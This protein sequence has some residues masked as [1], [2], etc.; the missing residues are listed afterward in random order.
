MPISRLKRVLIRTVWKNEEKDFTPWLQENLD[1]LGE[2]MNM[3]LSPLEREAPVGKAFEADLL[4][5]GPGGDLVVI[6]NQF[7]K[8]D[9]DHLG[10][11]LTYLVNLNAKTA[12]WICENPQPEH[13]EA[14][15]WLNKS[16]ASDIAFYLVRLEAFQMGDSPDCAPHFSIVAEPSS[17]MKEAGEAVE[18]LAERHVKR[19]EF[20]T[21]LLEESNKKLSLFS[22][23]SPSKDHWISAG[24][25]I[26][27]VVYQYLILKDE[28]RVQLTIEGSEQSKNKRIFDNLQ[29]KKEQIEKDF[30]E[31]LIWNRLDD[32]KVS[33]I[34]YKVADEGLR[35][36]EHWPKIIERM[37]ETMARFENAFISH[38]K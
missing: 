24:A 16:S 3:E 7:G 5:E 8:S 32:K 31:P 12:I 1:V 17:Q 20:W 13:K 9:H 30:G 15:D 25:G 21:Q 19:R 18:Q 2:T 26:S 35:N 38:I 33:Y 29:K 37:I 6:E 4:A 14:I 11:I 10:K 22:N 36:T 27:G 34:T 28:A 23:I